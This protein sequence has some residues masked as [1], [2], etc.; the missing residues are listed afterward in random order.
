MRENEVARREHG[1]REVRVESTELYTPPV[2]RQNPFRSPAAGKQGML[3]HK[4]KLQKVS[5]GAIKKLQEPC[6]PLFPQNPTVAAGFANRHGSSVTWNEA[7]LR[8]L[9]QRALF[10]RMGTRNQS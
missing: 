9:E 10:Y 8:P 1:C 7:H 4:V 6:V 2:L 5:K 3:K